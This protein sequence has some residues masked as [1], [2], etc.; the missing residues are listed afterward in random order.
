MSATEYDVDLRDMKFVLF[1]Q[2]KV[3]ETLAAVPRYKDFDRDMYEAV[4]DMAADI[5]K[6]VVSPVNK[7]SDREGVKLDSD[8]NVTTPECF[9]GAYRALVWRSRT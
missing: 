8:G 9:K 6:N 7:I 1:Q 5:A 3:H 4:L 2:M